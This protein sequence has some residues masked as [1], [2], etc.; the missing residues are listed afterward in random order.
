MGK[1]SYS[2]LLS[3]LSDS[4]LPFKLPASEKQSTFL[5]GAHSSFRLP[6]AQAVGSI[7]AHLL[8]SLKLISVNL[9]FC[10]LFKGFM[11]HS[12]AHTPFKALYF[13]Q[14][15]FLDKHTFSHLVFMFLLACIRFSFCIG[16][17]CTV[18]CSYI[19]AYRSFLYFY[20]LSLKKEIIGV[21]F[22]KNIMNYF[23]YNLFKNKLT[24]NLFLNNI[25]D[26]I[27]LLPYS[28]QVFLTSLAL[29]LYSFSL[30]KIIIIIIKT[31]QYSNSKQT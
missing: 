8:D 21:L 3:S 13:T 5:R 15:S 20:S 28:F 29:Q 27:F 18:A 31:K 14:T 17:H 12:N 11:S 1:Y 24:L 9:C 16:L 4:K 7:P 2:T 6:R 10:F 25:F 22:H 19:A 30:F 26:H 23:I